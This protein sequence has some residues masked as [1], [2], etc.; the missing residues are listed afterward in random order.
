MH[1][2]P[3]TDVIPALRTLCKKVIVLL[4]VLHC[5]VRMMPGYSWGMRDVEAQ[6][7]FKSEAASD[8]G[9][10]KGGRASPGKMTGRKKVLL[11]RDPLV[12][13][14]TRRALSRAGEMTGREDF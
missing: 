5:Y 7:Y 9:I 11:P 14:S 6:K 4:R 1:P 12:S 3:S 2:H 8:D 13:H 10:Q